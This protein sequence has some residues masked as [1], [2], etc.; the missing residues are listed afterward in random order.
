VALN[1]EARTKWNLEA[2]LPSRRSILLLVAVAALALAVFGWRRLAPG[3]PPAPA[4]RVTIEK[5]PINFANRIFDPARHP[6]DMPPMAFGEQAQC[7]SRFLSRADVSGEAERTDAVHA[8]VTITDIKITLQLD[9]TIWLPVSVT[10]HVLDHEEG[11]RQI[12]EHYYATADQVAERIAASFLGK[13]TEITGADLQAE[14]SK[15]LQQV[16]AEISAEYNRQ[17][18]P[19]PAQLRYDAITDHSRNNVAAPDAVAQ[20]LRES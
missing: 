19:E 3:G 14:L 1:A 7:D 12:S 11:H 13:K 5:Q 6:A 17:L 20:A 10:Q 15:S 9:I 18:N 4:G 8:T 16:S 2:P